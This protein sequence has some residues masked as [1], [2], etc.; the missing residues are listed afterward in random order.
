[1]ESVALLPETRLLPYAV[2]GFE[3]VR[4]TVDVPELREVLRSIPSCLT[5]ERD[6]S[7]T[8]T[9]SMTWSRPRT[10]IALT[11]LST[12]PVR[13]AARSP[14]CCASIGDAAVPVNIT[15]SPAPSI[16]ISD[17]GRTCFNAFANAVEVAFDGNVVGRN[18]LTGGVEE[19]DAGLPYGS[20]DDVGLLGRPHHG[21]GNLRICDQDIFIDLPMPSDTN[22]TLISAV[23]RIRVGLCMSPALAGIG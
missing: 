21:I 16:W 3:F 15:P 10:T 12:L 7:A 17:L 4:L 2:K 20:A 8:V 23:A 22:R 1:M 11:T 9:L 18:L 13:R 14:A 19:D 6:I 5:I